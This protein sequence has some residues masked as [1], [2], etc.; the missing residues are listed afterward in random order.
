[1]DSSTD[2]RLLAVPGSSSG[3][4][5]PVS[6]SRETGRPRRATRIFS[7]LRAFFDRHAPAGTGSP[8]RMTR[9][10]PSARMEIDGAESAST[11]SDPAACSLSVLTP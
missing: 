6:C 5:S 8:L 4:S 3:H 10:A 11:A 2:S 9:N 1:M 7:R